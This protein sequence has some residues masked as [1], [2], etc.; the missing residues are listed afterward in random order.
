MILQRQEIILLV[1][2]IFIT[3]QQK[4]ELERLHNSSCDGRVR[5]PCRERSCKV[6]FLY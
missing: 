2:K 5:D 3:D 6:H 4:V 1:M